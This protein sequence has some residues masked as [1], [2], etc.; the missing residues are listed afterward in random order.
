MDDVPA[1]IVRP[2]GYDDYLTDRIDEWRRT[3]A[4]HVERDPFLR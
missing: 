2:T 4:A 1:G 3:D